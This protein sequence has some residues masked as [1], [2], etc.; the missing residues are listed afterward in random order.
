MFSFSF[1]KRGGTFQG[2]YGS[3]SSSTHGDW[4]TSGSQLTDSRYFQAPQLANEEDEAD[5]GEEEFIQDSPELFTQ[6]DDFNL[7]GAPFTTSDLDSMGSSEGME[8]PQLAVCSL[9][10]LKRL[11]TGMMSDF[12]TP[13]D[14]VEVCYLTLG[15]SVSE[16][17]SILFVIKWHVWVSKSEWPFS[18]ALKKK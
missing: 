14:S 11:K 17:S 10:L 6:R 2:S 9:Q 12:S 8:T 15:S 3:Q 1:N 5:Y 7:Q 16:L 13:I 18:N 4:L